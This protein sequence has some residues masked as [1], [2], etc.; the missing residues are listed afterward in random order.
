[1]GY[2]IFT[3][4]T[5]YLGDEVQYIPQQL[6]SG[7]DVPRYDSKSAI[8]IGPAPQ[9]EAIS[10][11]KPYGQSLLI[12]D[13]I[14]LAQVSWNDLDKNGFIAG[15]MVSLNGCRFRC[16]LLQVGE[17]TDTPNEWDKALD[18]T[19]E[20]DALWYWYE[21]FFWG[22]NKLNHIQTARVVRGFS[23]ARH[24]S[25]YH[26][27]TRSIF[28][29]FRPVL[30][31]LSLGISILDCRLDGIDFRLSSIPGGEGFCPVLQ[32]IQDVFAGIPTET[33]VAMYTFMDG[34]RPIHVGESIR[35]PAKLTLTDRY[36]GD[37]YLVPWVISNGVTVASQALPQQN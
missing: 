4:G 23:S 25:S 8:S 5:L 28:I 35:D 7:G 29:G 16:R 30:E 18:A 3:F 22:A 2:D 24:L 20:N 10:W 11:I 36:F 17:K 12:A 9:Q 1:M 31:P 6:S 26:V 13:R 19:S 14:L 32:P 15:K 34:Q 37:E 27:E 33:E 21:M